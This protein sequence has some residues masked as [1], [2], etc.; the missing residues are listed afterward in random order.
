MQQLP[1]RFRPVKDSTGG[2]GQFQGSTAHLEA[3]QA[4]SRART[5]AARLCCSRD[6]RCLGVLGCAE[7]TR[8]LIVARVARWRYFEGG[9]CS[10][11]SAAA[12]GA[13]HLGVG[14][15]PPS[16]AA[17]SVHIRA[18]ATRAHSTAAAP[19]PPP[20][21]VRAAR[22]VYRWRSMHANSCGGTQVR[23]RRAASAQQRAT[24]PGGR[25]NG[26]RARAPRRDR[27]KRQQRQGGV[28]V[29]ARAGGARGVPR[30][31]ARWA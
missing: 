14:A 22:K 13:L 3:P 19:P 28:S 10:N 16:T 8:L 11:G 26:K 31:G 30:A 5:A 18:P 12:A 21:M 6:L 9:A 2:L 20:R 29:Q 15:K 23:S 25:Q 7:S 17:R 4:G 1:R 24:E 27:R